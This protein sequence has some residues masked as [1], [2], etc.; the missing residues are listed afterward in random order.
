MEDAF[1][2]PQ[3]SAKYNFGEVAII[4]LAHAA[5][6]GVVGIAAVAVSRVH[7][8]G[9]DYVGWIIRFIRTGCNFGPP[10]VTQ[11]ELSRLFAMRDDAKFLRHVGWE[12]ATSC[13]MEP[14]RSCALHIFLALAFGKFDLREFAQKAPI[15]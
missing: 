13:S 11:T 8:D 12:L 14:R 6:G 10:L 9:S 1:E 15:K 4:W 7:S 5:C 3:L 2:R